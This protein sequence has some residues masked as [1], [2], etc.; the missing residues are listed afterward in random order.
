ME[1]LIKALCDDCEY[2]RWMAAALQQIENQK[3]INGVNAA[4]ANEPD[5]VRG[6]VEELIEGS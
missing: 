5:D 3:A 4:L 6:I 2:C 1:P